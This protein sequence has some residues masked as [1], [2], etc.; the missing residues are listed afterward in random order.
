[1]ECFYRISTQNRIGPWYPG[2]AYHMEWIR[3]YYAQPL[4]GRDQEVV[5]VG[6][7]EDGEEITLRCTSVENDRIQGW[8]MR[9]Q[10]V[11]VAW[12]REGEG[13][14]TLLRFSPSFHPSS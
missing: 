10:R 7:T 14:A 6:L 11:E 1:M 5:V 13:E 9:G 4:R 12:C 2:E 3:S 8:T